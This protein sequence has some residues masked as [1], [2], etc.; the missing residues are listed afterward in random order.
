MKGEVPSSTVT[1][2][3]SI[4]WSFHLLKEKYPGFLK[5]Y[6]ETPHR[7]SQIN[8][9]LFLVCTKESEQSTPGLSPCPGKQVTEKTRGSIEFV[10]SFTWRKKPKTPAYVKS[11]KKI[12]QALGKHTYSLVTYNALRRCGPGF[13]LNS[14]EF[15]T[16]WSKCKE[17]IPA[18][19][20]AFGKHSD[21][22]CSVDTPKHSNSCQEVGT[23]LTKLVT[24]RT[25]DFDAGFKL[26]EVLIVISYHENIEFKSLVRYVA[27]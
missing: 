18:G 11:S 23:I 17:R 20:T 12:L 14:L 7:N 1:S 27:Y 13:Y 5:S 22:E 4:S 15:S 6:L 10:L 19:K 25:S 8:H 24:A 9:H 3:L 2:V 16:A 26:N 21:C